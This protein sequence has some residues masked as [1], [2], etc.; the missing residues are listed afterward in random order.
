MIVAMESDSFLSSS[1]SPTAGRLVLSHT[2]Q[3]LAHRGLEKFAELNF[4]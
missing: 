3:L 2:P 1:G 4:F